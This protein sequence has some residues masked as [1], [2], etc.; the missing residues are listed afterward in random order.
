MLSSAGASDK[1]RWLPVTIAARPTRHSFRFRGRNFLALVLRPE[2]P[3]EGWLTEL[4]DWLARSPNFFSGKPLILDVAGLTVGREDV[5]NILAELGTRA[6]RIIGIE[7]ADPAILDDSLPPL[8]TGGRTAGSV[9][10]VDAIAPRPSAEGAAAGAKPAVPTAKPTARQAAKPASRPAGA[11]DRPPTPS[12]LVETPVR[13]GQSIHNADGDVIILGSVASGAEVV[14]AGSIHVY[15][16]LRGRALAGAYGDEN[17]RIFCRR[18]EAELIAVG[19][20]Y[21]VTDE[22]EARLRQKP[23]QAWLDGEELKIATLDQD[24]KEAGKWRKSSS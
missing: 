16:T 2:M 13:S 22:I 18:F 20:Y 10:A 3:L 6:I 12:I 24:D 7:G 9:E 11:K 23:I 1:K 8:L 5:V 14:A 19:G 17:A 21:K 15:G 4:D